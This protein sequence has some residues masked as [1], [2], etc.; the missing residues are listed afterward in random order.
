MKA[1][2]VAIADIQ[3]P[4]LGLKWDGP[5]RQAVDQRHSWGNRAI[6]KYLIRGE[7]LYQGVMGRSWSSESLH[8]SVPYFYLLPSS[9][10][11]APMLVELPHSGVVRGKL[12]LVRVLL[13]CQECSSHSRLLW[14]WGGLVMGKRTSFFNAEITSDTDKN[15]LQ[16]KSW[17]MSATT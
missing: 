14:K 6:R 11:R 4:K 17:L 7:Q 1:S 8:L 16:N 3:V 12:V 2:Q 9:L 5:Q 13:L 15:F 10:P